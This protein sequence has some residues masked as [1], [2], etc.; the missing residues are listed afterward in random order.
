MIMNMI[1]CREWN[2]S[3]RH[4]E[5]KQDCRVND[6]NVN[7]EETLVPRRLYNDLIEWLN[8]GSMAIVEH[9]QGFLNDCDFDSA[10]GLFLNRFFFHWNINEEIE[11]IERNL[12]KPFLWFVRARKNDIVMNLHRKLSM[13]NKRIRH[14]YQISFFSFFGQG[15]KRVTWLTISSPFHLYRGC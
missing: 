7:V 2:N 9:R 14:A 11:Q 3:I 1:P 4:W 12:F 8:H 10:I 6:L 15:K 13:K 5:Y